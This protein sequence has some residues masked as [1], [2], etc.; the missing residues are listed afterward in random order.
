MFA[1]VTVIVIFA[2]ITPVLSLVLVTHRMIRLVAERL[3]FDGR[4]DLDAVMQV[5]AE[6]P[7]YGEGLAD[8]LDV[9]GGLEVGL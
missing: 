2:L 3:A 6:R 8:A 9:G 4:V 5:A 1:P 7:K